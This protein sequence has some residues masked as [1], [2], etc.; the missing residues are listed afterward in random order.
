[1]LSGIECW[2]AWYD[3]SWTTTNPNAALPQRL[4]NNDGTKTY[5]STSMFWLKDASYLRMKY[6][7]IGYI[8]PTNLYNNLGIGSVKVYFS[9]SNLFMFS[10][11]NK[12]YYD[13]EIGDGF[14]YPNMRSY[15]V[16]VNVSF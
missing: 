2:K 10:K 6:L 11:F 13:P 1:M 14:S 3:Q 15:N 16:G 5:T 8:I 4:S 12:N 7:N 9:G